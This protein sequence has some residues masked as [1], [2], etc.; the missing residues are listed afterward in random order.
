MT[1][2]CRAP[3]GLRMGLSICLFFG[4]LAMAALCPRAM[5]QALEEDPSLRPQQTGPPVSAPFKL[6]V[7]ETRFLPPA[8]YGQWSVTATLIASDMGDALSPV[9]HDIWLLARDGDQVTLSNP[10]TGAFASVS[11]DRVQ[12][13]TATFH[14]GVVLRPG[15]RT[16]IERPTVTV[17]GD[18]LY[19]ETT[20]EYRLLRNG[21]VERVYHARFRIEAERLSPARAQWQA[22][23][24]T[25]AFEI[26][27]IQRDPAAPAKSPV[28]SPDRRL[29][30]R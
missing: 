26:E 10:V 27:D 4:A 18:R 22:V 3:V 11:V 30:V 6:Q 2:R 19:G 29:Y 8:M 25:P 14:H 20:H 13:Q 23:P 17:A 24:Q 28:T 5:G 15:R 9:A 16:L 21:V 1:P 7:S 12:G